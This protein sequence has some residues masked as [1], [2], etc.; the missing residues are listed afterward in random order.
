[1]FVAG[2]RLACIYG[3]WPICAAEKRRKDIEDNAF[4]I[5]PCQHI[6]NSIHMTVN[7]RIEVP[8]F[9]DD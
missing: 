5:S 1:M 7:S 6:C 2:M 9:E 3:G 8:S 4:D